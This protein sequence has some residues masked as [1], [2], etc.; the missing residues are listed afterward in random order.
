MS[1]NPD[2]LAHLLALVPETF[3]LGGIRVAWVQRCTR[4]V[5]QAS[6]FSFHVNDC[7]PESQVN[8]AQGVASL[9]ACVFQ[10]TTSAVGTFRTWRDVQLESVMRSKADIG[11]IAACTKEVKLDLGAHFAASGMVPAAIVKDSGSD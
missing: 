1:P 11:S 7:T 6:S 8:D 9:P 4:D 3:H 2:T 10:T 5:V